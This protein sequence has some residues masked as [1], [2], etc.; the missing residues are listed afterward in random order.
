[1]EW[2]DRALD[3]AEARFQLRRPTTLAFQ[4]ASRATIDGRSVE[5]FCSNDYLGL[6]FDSRLVAALRSAAE[7]CGAGS[8]A[9][10]LVSG[11]A[12]AHD[13]AESVLS[14]WLGTQ[15]ALLFSSGYAA[16]VGTIAALAGPDDVVFSDERNH[17]SIIDGCRLARSRTLVFPHRDGDALAGSIARARPFRR[18][19]IVTESVFSMDG[20]RADVRALRELCDQEGLGLY[21][22]EA[23]ALGV[24]GPAGA[25]VLAEAGVRADVVVGTLGKALGLAGAFVAGSSSLRAY[26]WNHAR[27]LV[28]STGLP[29]MIA[30]AVIAAVRLAAEPALR[31]KLTANVQRFRQAL[32]ARGIAVGGDPDVP[33]VP[34][35]LGGAERANATTARLLELGFFVQAIRPPTVPRETARLR[36][37]LG[38]AHE[39]PSI[40]AL[41]AA[42]AEVTATS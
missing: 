9:S 39:P 11:N 42:L 12:P 22:D 14:G 2:I 10:R 27:S 41:A 19:W 13:A 21:V 29:P 23:H 18:G 34:L 6:R 35:L 28:Y 17:A 5:V 32:A 36:I 8:G 30:A 1:V 31:S 38:A 16:N 26:L 40:D 24:L 25:G 20:D 33:I 7:D 15:A 37:T 4:S 3:D